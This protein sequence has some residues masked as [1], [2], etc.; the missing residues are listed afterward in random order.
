MTIAE[1]KKE[2]RSVQQAHHIYGLE[3]MLVEIAAAYKNETY[4]DK[5]YMLK[6][7][8]ECIDRVNLEDV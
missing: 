5:E 4:V 6:L 3:C 7:F 8:A 2:V 1:I